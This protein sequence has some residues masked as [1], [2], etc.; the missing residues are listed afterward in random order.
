MGE[1]L[2]C[3][4]DLTSLASDESNIEKDSLKSLKSTSDVE[5]EKG[6][7]KEKKRG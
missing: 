5:D 4:E 7:R 1:P 3:Q 6:P 2:P